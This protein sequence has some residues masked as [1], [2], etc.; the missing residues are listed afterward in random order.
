MTQYRLELYNA[1][2]RALEEQEKQDSLLTHFENFTL[3]DTTINIFLTDMYKERD[4]EILTD[5]LLSMQ[6][7]KRVK[8]VLPQK[9]LTITYNPEETTPQSIAYTINKLGYHHIGRG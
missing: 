8:P 2:K 5:T 9:R 7:V 3:Q 6:G 4:S 1:L